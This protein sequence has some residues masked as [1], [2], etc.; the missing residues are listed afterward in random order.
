[1]NVTSF[2]LSSMSTTSLELSKRLNEL[3]VKKMSCMA[4]LIFSDTEK[5]IKPIYRPLDP[6]ISDLELLASHSLGEI[7]EMLPTNITTQTPCGKPG[8]VSYVL[9]LIKSNFYCI[10][11]DCLG[12]CENCNISDNSCITFS[13][14]ENSAEPAGEL[15]AWC[16]ENGHVKPSDIRG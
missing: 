14:R 16:I 5:K 4:Y 9:T 7:L 11:Y 10:S 1:M 3:G 15:L 2:E 12:G 8:V 6:T 13:D